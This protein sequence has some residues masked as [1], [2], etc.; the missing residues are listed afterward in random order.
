MLIAAANEALMAADA[1]LRALAPTPLDAYSTNMA[2]RC[3]DADRARRCGGVPT[4]AVATV[5]NQ[6]CPVQW[7]V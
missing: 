6:P 7:P 4:A 1:F 5:Q 2:A 3:P